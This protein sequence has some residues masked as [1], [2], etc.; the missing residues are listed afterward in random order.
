MIT[1]SIQMARRK[2]K[3]S[4][5]RRFTGVNVLNLAEAYALTGVW[6]EAAFRT[7]P[8]EFFTGVV[9][10]KYNPGRDGSAVITLPELLGAGPGGVGGNFGG[11]AG[12]YDNL[13]NSVS[14]NIGGLEGLVMPAVKSAGISIG[15][16]IA[17]KITRKPRSMLNAQLRAFGVGDMVRV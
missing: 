12:K 6:T 14:S 3:R 10:G 1:D 2:N 16:K 13:Q 7:S 11:T 15:F 8:I 4:T 17:K 5:R 9:G